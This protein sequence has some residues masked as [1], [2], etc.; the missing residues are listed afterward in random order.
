MDISAPEEPSEDSSIIKN[1][2]TRL[3]QDG[4][5]NCKMLQSNPF[6][7]AL[8]CLLKK[9]K[10]PGFHTNALFTLWQ[11]T[12]QIT[13]TLSSFRCSP[14]H[15]Q[16]TAPAGRTLLTNNHYKVPHGK[17]R[18][19]TSAKAT[20][21]HTDTTRTARPEAPQHVFLRV[22]SI[23]TSRCGQHWDCVWSSWHNFPI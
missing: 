1:S 14:L 7:Q 10:T 9:N 6:N 18:V 20:T 16:S 23:L 13:L 22:F 12:H 15:C 4:D 19:H 21:Q 8:Y 3:H 2:L 11:N 5:L 17:P